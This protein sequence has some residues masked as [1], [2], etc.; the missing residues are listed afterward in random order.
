MNRVMSLIGGPK[1]S[2]T[3]GRRVAAICGSTIDDFTGTEILHDSSHIRFCAF[4]P[5]RSNRPFKSHIL[6][7]LAAFNGF[8]TVRT[9]VFTEEDIGPGE[10]EK[11]GSDGMRT[12]CFE[13]VRRTMK[14]AVEPALGPAT[15]GEADFT[16]CL[17]CC[18]FSER[19]LG[20]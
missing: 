8:R 14:D 13:R 16:F 17:A 6:P 10:Y 15:T 3:H 9:D 7:K 2:L 5:T 19:G 1:I 18:R 11:M 12:A 4:D 20:S